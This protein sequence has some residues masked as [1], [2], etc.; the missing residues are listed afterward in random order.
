MEHIRK[1]LEDLENL[2]KCIAKIMGERDKHMKNKILYEHAIAD[3]LGSIQE[4]SKRVLEAYADRDGLRSEEI[5]FL[6]GQSVNKMG[7]SDDVWTN[8]YNKLKDV[9]DYH[10]KNQNLNETG[11]TRDV[12]YFFKTAMNM[13]KIEGRFSAE[14]NMGR[15]IDVYASYNEFINFHKYRRHRENEHREGEILRWKRKLNNQ[16][17]FD[18]KDTELQKRLE[19]TEIDY[20]TYL[21]TFDRCVCVEGGCVCSDIQTD[22]SVG[23]KKQ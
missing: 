19:F 10:R 17:D 9:K 12:P 20:I 22:R 7:Q 6:A 3:S 14:E 2:D 15:R 4:K 11:E 8:F 5:A 1:E 21:K 16:D 18:L 23:R 13:E